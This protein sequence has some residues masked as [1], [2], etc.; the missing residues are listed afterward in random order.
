MPFNHQ[1]HHSATHR[2]AYYIESYVGH[3][4]NISTIHKCVN[5]IFFFMA[6]NTLKHQGD[7]IPNDV[8]DFRF[9][10]ALTTRNWQKIENKFNRVLTV[11]L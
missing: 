7:I 1:P 6:I 5:I 4:I 9:N 2:I 10:I 11:K 3:I 8:S